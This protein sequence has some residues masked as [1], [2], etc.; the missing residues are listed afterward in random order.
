MDLQSDDDPV[1][2]INWEILSTGA[3]PNGQDTNYTIEPSNK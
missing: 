1:T 3:I 2:P